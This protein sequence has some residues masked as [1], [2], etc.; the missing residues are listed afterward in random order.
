MPD[1]PASIATE[2]AKQIPIKDAYN[3]ALSPG[4]KQTGSALEDLTKTARLILAPLQVGAALQDRLSAFLDK[5]VRGIPDERRIPPPKQILGPTLEAMKYEDDDSPIT[6]MFAALLNKSMDIEVVHLAH[7]AFPQIIRQLSPDE[8]QI[9]NGIFQ[10][11]EKGAP[12]KRQIAMDLSYQP[13]KAWKNIRT[14][15]DELSRTNLRFP[16]NFDFY[17]Q[18]LYS[19]GLAGVYK[20]GDEVIKEGKTQVGS[21]IFEEYRLTDFGLS[22]MRA[23]S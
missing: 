6:E 16:D 9:L 3:D 1:I 8:A 20:I 18:H 2:L 4:M 14:E 21:R 23:V 19:M 22:F 13:T 7:P 11:Q 12:A 15:V 10:F 17:F 5:S